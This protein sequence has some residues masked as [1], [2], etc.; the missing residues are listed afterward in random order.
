MNKVT[1]TGYLTSDIELK[2]TK[3]NKTVANV[4]I[5]V[6]IP[7]KEEADFFKVILWGKLAERCH[8]FLEK[9]SFVL[10]E[11][12]LSKEKYV[13]SDGKRVEK[14]VIVAQDIEFL[15]RPSEKKTYTEKDSNKEA[16]IID[17][18]ENIVD[19]DEF[20]ESIDGDDDDVGEYV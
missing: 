11:G 7:F 6:H 20:F 14:V 9:G 15:R 18:I 2:R 12:R 5:A 8:K 4:D 3:N 13:T 10:I 17:D 1:L 16:K 19:I